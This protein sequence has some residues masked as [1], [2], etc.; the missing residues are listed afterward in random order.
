V[1][2][3]DP[4]SPIVSKQMLSESTTVTVPSHVSLPA[5]QR[6]CATD[7]LHVVT[8]LPPH[9]CGVGDYGFF[10]NEKIGQLSGAFPR[11][12]APQLNQSAAEKAHH[13]ER[14]LEQARFV[15]LEYSPY[16]YQR[17][18]IPD[19]LLST[20][21]KWKASGLSNLLITVFHELYATGKIWSTA[22]WTSPPQRY[23]ARAIAELSDGAIT[24][25][26]RQAA[27]L[28]EWNPKLDL[29][30][31]AVPSNVGELATEQLGGPREIALVVFGQSG[32][33]ERSYLRNA[34]GWAKIR[35][36]MPHAVVHDI[37]VPTGL[38]ISELVGLR[39][40]QHGHLSP[41][42]TSSLLANSQF[43][44]LDYSNST[45]NK[46]GVFAAYCA[47]G[48]VPI[49]FNHSTPDSSTLRER[50][51]FLTADS[52]RGHAHE[53]A[54]LSQNAHKW[55][56]GHDLTQHSRAICEFLPANAASNLDRAIF[57]H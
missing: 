39:C 29:S 24:T 1:R 34:Q 14:A 11:L 27:I 3:P 4:G 16:A 46:S 41:I 43:G 42:E 53:L 19:W 22:F 31:L 51:H 32:T 28:R 12:F 10:V 7:I 20:L 52:L 8:A 17:Y 36:L 48:T 55:Y 30:I 56:L 23:V 25:T 6:R 38:P 47:H 44:I 13:L 15:I 35:D 26:P 2:I 5:L 49:V 9:V 33:R 37:G 45:L 57:A 54:H 21:K 18:G 50:E 40:V